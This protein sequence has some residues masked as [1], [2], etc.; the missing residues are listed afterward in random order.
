VNKPNFFI[1]GAPKCGTTAL[2][3]Y[4]DEHPNI[5]ISTPKEPHY[6]ANDFPKMRHVSEL[7]EYIELFNDADESCTAIGEG[8]VWNLYSDVAVENIMDFDKDAKIIVMLRN[9]VDLVY[10][11]HSQH[12]ITL[13]E[14]Q[15]DFIKAWDLQNERANGN[16]LPPKCREPK[17]LQYSAFGKLG[18]QIERLFS[19]V[20]K[21]QVHIIIFDDFS[22]DTKSSY[23]AVL[24]FLE[25]PLYDK[26]E[27]P[28]VN[29][30]KSHK[31]MILAFFTQSPPR[32]LVRF[33]FSIKKLFR[34]EN[35][36]ILEKIRV[37]NRSTKP[38]TKLDN[39]FRSKLAD[40]F[41]SDISKLSK[42]IERDLNHWK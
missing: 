20:P 25:V 21:S 9:P 41:K 13:D 22:K 10:S 2:C 32:W 26:Q 19:T 36:G 29:E 37:I 33:A 1:V 24:K 11:M 16:S 8:S 30:N 39:D 14:N 7:S 5:F 17:L 23:E 27:F 34:I 12:Q 4:L 15:I 3:Q 31:N 6:F 18:D 35:L 40:Y 38:R 42:L 28:R